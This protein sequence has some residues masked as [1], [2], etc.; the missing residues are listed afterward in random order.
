MI[1][2]PFKY[3]Y[4]NPFSLHPIV[5]CGEVFNRSSG[6][7][8]AQQYFIALYYLLYVNLIITINDLLV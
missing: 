5:L 1:I 4:H 3:P 8:S 6:F 2:V 7:T